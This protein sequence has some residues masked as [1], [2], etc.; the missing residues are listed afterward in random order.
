[1]PDVISLGV[2]EPDFDTP[3]AGR[4]GGRPQSLRAGRTHYTSNYGTI[5]LRRALATHLERLYGVG[6]DPETEIL[7]HR[8][9]VR[10]L[11]A[12]PCARSIDPGDEVVL[13]E[14][15]YVAYLPAIIFNGGVPVFVSDAPRRRLRARPGGGRGGDH[16]ADQGRSSWATR[17]TRPAPCSPEASCARSPSIAERH[18][19]LVVSDEIY[20][21]LVY[22]GHRHVRVQ[23]AARDARADDPARR[24]LE[25]VR[26]DRLADRLRCARRRTSS[27]ASSRSTSTRSCR[28]RRPPRTRRSWRST[29][30]RAGRRADASRVRPAPADVRRRPQRHRPARRSSRTAPSTP[31]RRSARPA[32][33]SEEFSERLLFEQ[34]VA[35]IPGSAFGPSGEGHVRATLATTLR[36]PRGG[37]R[38][39]PRASSSSARR[40][41]RMTRRSAPA[42][43]AT[44]SSS[45]SR[46][47]SSCGPRRR[48][49]A[50]ARRT[51]A[52]PRRTRH[53]CP[54][55][56][57]L[58]GALPVINRA[59]RR[60]RPRDRPRDRRRR[61]PTCTRWDRKNYF[62]P[63]PAQGLPDQPVRPAAGVRRDAR[64]RDVRG[65]GHGRHHA[66]APRGGHG[67]AA[68]RTDADG[69]G[70]VSAWST[71]TARASR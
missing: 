18:D 4:R 35:V 1:M 14:P 15:S 8:R 25:G 19:L 40:S 45:A 32:S 59:R 37:A 7:H 49:S 65:P 52:A 47:T 57:G 3:A 69:G 67:A 58:P 44:R 36:G 54:V 55:C 64:R 60:A 23:R 9:R 11:A 43:R 50:A 56:L 33:T 29:T 46:S 2:G 41:A 42:D 63:G 27:R 61:S 5:E 48:C 39:H 31:S 10:G 38:P 21:R 17:A 12:S 71:S 24:L 68:P 70:R 16:A 22:G 6:Y 13:H 66:R 28:R 26:D 34:Q 53:T 20:D 51:C 30:R 62:Y